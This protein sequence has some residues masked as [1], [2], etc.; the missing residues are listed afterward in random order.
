MPPKQQ[1][2]N[3][4]MNCFHIGGKSLPLPLSLPPKPTSEITP[5]HASAFHSRTRPCPPTLQA[6]SAPT[7]ASCSLSRFDSRATHAR[8]LL[9]AALASVP[10]GF[11]LVRVRVPDFVLNQAQRKQ[12]KAA[13][14]YSASLFFIFPC[15][16][17]HSPG[18]DLRFSLFDRH[19]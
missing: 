18:V 16:R 10:Y 19:L 6:H 1:P 15:S 13:L 9:P 11:V 14:C 2:N 3:Q 7:H 4:T 5:P 8:T 12:S 17:K